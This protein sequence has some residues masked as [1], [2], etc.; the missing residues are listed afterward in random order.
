MP[1]GMTG[2]KKVSDFLID[3]KLSLPEKE[4]VT[5]VESGGEIV[6]VVGKRIDE[7]VKSDLTKKRIHADQPI[8]VPFFHFTNCLESFWLACS[9]LLGCYWL[10]TSF[11]VGWR[12]VEEQ[13]R[14]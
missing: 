2:F 6:W 8:E 13:W 11:T 1:L 5:V 3:E 9:W 4:N 12:R 7:R 10:A 14:K